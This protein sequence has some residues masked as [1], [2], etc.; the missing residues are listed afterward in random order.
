MWLKQA[1]KAPL[2]VLVL[3]ACQEWGIPPWQV[4]KDCSEQW[5]EWWL[6]YRSE[7]NQLQKEEMDKIRRKNL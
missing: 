7:K 1:G 3:E 5:W 6:I 4:E 2:E